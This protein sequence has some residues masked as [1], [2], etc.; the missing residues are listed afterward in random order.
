M[1]ETTKAINLGFAKQAIK[2]V[3]LKMTIG[4]DNKPW[5]N[6]I[7]LFSAESAHDC[8]ARNREQK[9]QGPRLSK[10]RQAARQAEKS[11]CG[12]CGEQT[13]IAFFYLYD[14]KIGPLEYINRT[15]ADHSFVVIG[16]LADSPLDKP[17]EWG[18]DCVI[19]DPWA[20]EVYNLQNVNM[21]MY[22]NKSIFKP[23]VVY[24]YDPE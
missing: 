17:L 18:D 16:R 2:Y 7:T 13:A 5:N 19:C 4:A 3:D 10:L 12:N 11:G 20:R 1:S 21:K 14:R 6:F 22:G 15:Q 23:Q 24:R 9:Y 8:V